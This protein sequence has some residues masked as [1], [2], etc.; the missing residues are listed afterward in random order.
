MNA[1]D[2]W[3]YWVLL[4]VAIPANLYPLF[5]LFRPWRSTPQG[6]ALMTKSLGNMMLIDIIVAFSLWGD[7]PGR[8]WLR[9]IAFTVFAVGTTYL[10][11]SLLRVPNAKQYPP[12]T[13]NPWRNQDDD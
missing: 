11:I 12:F 1:A 6:R 2:H 13:W 8:S 3:V 7:Y 10:L 9:A 4:Y 5:Y